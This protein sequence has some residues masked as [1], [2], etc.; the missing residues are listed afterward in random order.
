MKKIVLSIFCL[1]CV[2]SLN[3]CSSDSDEIKEPTKQ[4]DS[5]DGGE[6]HQEPIIKA[7]AATKATFTGKDVSSDNTFTYLTLDLDEDNEE[8]TYVEVENYG[9]DYSYQLKLRGVYTSN[10]YTVDAVVKTEVKQTKV[11]PGAISTD[12]KLYF[13]LSSLDMEVDFYTATLLEVDSE[14]ELVL[15]N[16]LST[17][18]RNIRFV[19]QGHS[20]FYTTIRASQTNGAISST[21]HPKGFSIKMDPYPLA[22]AK[23]FIFSGEIHQLAFYTVTDKTL[24]K[25]TATRTRSSSAS[26]NGGTS[27]YTSITFISPSNIGLVAGDYLVRM[28]V[29]K[30]GTGIIKTSPFQ[31]FKVKN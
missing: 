18:T 4:S 21:G 3:S 31:K 20:D 2:F 13:K 25:K 15:Q 28:E 7:V 5:S 24:V 23:P 17:D 29:F 6:V 10:I 26:S 8:S 9:T 16:S 19:D 22:K 12:K 30:L 27:Y 1:L 11:S 14:N